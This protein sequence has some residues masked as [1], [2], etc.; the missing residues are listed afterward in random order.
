MGID[1]YAAV[2]TQCLAWL[3]R[4]TGEQGDGLH[5]LFERCASLADCL[6]LTE[7]R[8][9]RMRRCPHCAGDK[10]YRHGILHG[11]QRYRGRQCRRSFNALTATPQAFIRPR[12]KWLPFLQC[13]LGSMTAGAAAET[14]GNHRSTSFRWR[15]RF[16]AMAKDDRPKPLSGIVEAGKTYLLESQ[17][18]S[19]RLTRPPRRAAACPT[20]WAGSTGS[21]VDT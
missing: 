20:T 8:G 16:L 18:G 4:L 11:R 10:L 13:M 17:K 12:E 19:R 14:T 7:E 21:T 2:R 6:A 3:T 9:T 5:Q 15:H 1:E